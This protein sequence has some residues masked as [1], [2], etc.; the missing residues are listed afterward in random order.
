MPFQI[1][2]TKTEFSRCHLRSQQSRNVK[3]ELKSTPPASTV[4]Q[5]SEEVPNFFLKVGPE[6]LHE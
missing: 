3:P 5:I 4:R 2:A 6:P 1:D